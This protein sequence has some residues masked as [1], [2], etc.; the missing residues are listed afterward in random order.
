MA[1]MET[2]SSCCVLRS[3]SY[4]RVEIR[5]KEGETGKREDFQRYLSLHFSVSA[6]CLLSVWSF[7]SSPCFSNPEFC[8]LL[9][10]SLLKEIPNANSW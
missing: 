2:Q 7:F 1:G 9:V 3:G 8:F 10:L 4:N 5:I 6:K